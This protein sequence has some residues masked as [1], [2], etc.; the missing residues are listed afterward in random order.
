MVKESQEGGKAK[1]NFEESLNEIERIVSEIEDGDLPLDEVVPRFKR[2]TKLISEC[3][4][5]LE[6]VEQQIKIIESEA[7]LE[8]DDA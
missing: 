5:M 6:V 4:S 7:K 8:Q 2:A 1:K 3:R